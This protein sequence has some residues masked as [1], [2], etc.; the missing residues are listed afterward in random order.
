[1]RVHEAPSVISER[2]LALALRLRIADL[3]DEMRV[4]IGS[5]SI[6]DRLAVAPDASAAWIYGAYAVLLSR[7]PDPEGLAGLRR[8]LEAG[9]PPTALL[10]ELRS[11]R[12]GRRGRA[13]LPADP[14]DVFVIGCHLLVFGRSPSPSELLEARSALDHGQ[15]QDDYLA[16]LAETDTARRALRFPP[17]SPDR[18]AALAVAIQRATGHAEVE[19]VTV[20]LRADLIAGA[21]LT[22]LLRGE[23]DRHASRL[24]ARIRV[25]LALQSLAAHAEAIAASLLAQQESALTR[26]LIWRLKLD[27]WQTTSSL[28][29]R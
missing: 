16:T 14:R 7:V 27:E 18:N 22:A 19:S 6:P 13:R 15:P 5:S 23:L 24:L 10:H 1:L 4:A 17:A 2:A 21:S 25:R 8:G 12:E 20:R 3:D 9:M 11:S 28:D 29:E 26:D